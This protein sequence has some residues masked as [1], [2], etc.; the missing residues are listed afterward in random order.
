MRLKLI[1]VLLLVLVISVSLRPAA[2]AQ[3][4]QQPYEA[5][6]LHGFVLKQYDDTHEIRLGALPLV[7]SF[8]CNIRSDSMKPNAP[9]SWNIICQVRLEIISNKRITV[10]VFP[11]LV[12]TLLVVHALLRL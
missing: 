10:I 1:H 2:A 4:A 5:S 8:D 12:V 7:G 6:A 9:R 11:C 3:P